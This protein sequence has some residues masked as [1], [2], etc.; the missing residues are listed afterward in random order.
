ML[1]RKYDGS[2]IEVKKTDFKNDK[3]YY[4]F[5]MNIKMNM[6]MDMKTGSSVKDTNEIKE[7]RYYSKQAID[8]LLKT[9]A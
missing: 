9:F 4:T 6:D 2:I 3:L 5:I 7:R 1:F 8:N